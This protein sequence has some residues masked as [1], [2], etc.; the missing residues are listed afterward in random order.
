V[1]GQY[2]S[3]P[4]YALRNAPAT[5]KAER[6]TINPQSQE[7]NIALDVETN[8]YSLVNVH[9]NRYLNEL[10]RFGANPFS[11]HWNTYVLTSKNGRYAIQNAENG[12]TA[13]WTLSTDGKTLVPNLK[14]P[15]ADEQYIFELIPIE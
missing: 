5:L 1:N 8:R 6:D 10:C 13:F 3:D 4:D 11:V 7:W 15:Q 12:G 9:A 2:L 14:N